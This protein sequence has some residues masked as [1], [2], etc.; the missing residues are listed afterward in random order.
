MNLVFKV[1]TVIF[2]L[3]KDILCLKNYINGVL[4][5]NEK[6]ID[7]LLSNLVQYRVSLHM[8]LNDVYFARARKINNSKEYPIYNDVSILSYIPLHLLDKAPLGRFNKKRQPMYYGSLF[9]T[10]D[11]NLNVPFNE[12]DVEKGD[13]VN[14][15]IS[16]IVIDINIIV[17]GLFSL[18]ENKGSFI[19]C[20]PIFEKINEY[21]N[22]THEK[23]L[24]EAIKTVD[25]FFNEIITKEGNERVYNITSSLGNIYL[26][27]KTID[28]ILY[29]STK[30][31]KVLNIMLRPS[32]IDKKVEYLEAKISLAE[33]NESENTMDNYELDT[34]NIKNC[35]IQWMKQTR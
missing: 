12:I 9:A 2:T 30:A 35:K 22:N 7:I 26:E 23:K 5:L 4:Y 10:Y 29:Q 21:Y 8:P 15:L 6:D 28:G 24:L 3:S 32:I 34:G 20:H 13:Y 18:I 1:Y 14:T 27:D 25:N 16:R 19:K 17:I 11:Y 33:N 31:S